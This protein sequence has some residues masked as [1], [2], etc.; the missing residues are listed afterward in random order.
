MRRGT[1]LR[2][3][4]AAA[5]MI[6][7]SVPP[8]SAAVE[9]ITVVIDDSLDPARVEVE[10]GTRV[11]WRN[12]DG[13]RHRIRSTS[14]PRE[15]DSGNIDSG[16]RFSFTFNVEGEYTYVDDRDR[17]NTAYHGTIVVTSDAAPPDPGEPP[18]PP[19][20]TGDV[21]IVD[22]RYQPA[23]IEVA[24]GA[25]ITWAN[26]DDRPHTVTANDRS[27]DSGVFDTG[28]SWAKTFTAAGSFAYFCTIHP[29]MVGTVI[30]TGTDGEPP[31][32]PP[33]TT[34]PPPAPPPPTPPPGATDVTIV[35]FN[36]A[37]GL[38]EV[39]VGTTVSWDNAG[40][41]PHTVTADNGSFDSGIMST[42]D[43]YNRTFN[44]AGTFAYLC[45][46][47]PEMV[48]TI[49]V[50]GGGGGGGEP[51][52][53]EPPPPDGDPPPPPPPPGASGV[54]IVDND[55]SPGTLRIA[56][57]TTVTWRNAG[58]LPHT[59]TANSGAFDSGFLSA[60]DSYRRTFHQPGTF[61]YLC[62][63]HPEMVG[64]VEV[65]GSPTGPDEPPPTVPPDVATP[66][67]APPSE[68]GPDSL[69]PLDPAQPSG[70]AIIDNAYDP[71]TLTVEA[72]TTVTW[73][74]VGVLPHTVTADDGA[75]DSGFLMTGDDYTLTLDTPGTFAYICTIHP[76]M[77][78]T[79]NV[80]AAAAT[81]GAAPANPA[82]SA[83]VASGEHAVAAAS[84]GP[85]GEAE[86]PPGALI[87][88]VLAGS[89]LATMVVFAI[90][91]ARFGK[92]AAEAR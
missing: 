61:A 27:W 34:T 19:P 87:A 60:G 36:F 58:A 12:D 66:D 51:P 38:L 68:A 33:P 46:L 54:N 56:T 77:V 15:F 9:T 49:V 24:V 88:Y 48:G 10:R 85:T 47:H 78:G 41:A 67:G 70:V 11:T 65:S 18:P 50:G 75:F 76:E 7:V 81:N 90:G 21:D 43:T 30:V 83:V 39:P 14:G 25:T 92:A 2:L 59:V 29:D 73:T 5:V 72:G 32:P 55:F 86:S 31:P 35:D 23:T 4:L 57:G 84:T 26:N 40:V 53:P 6:S 62:T 16:E 3:W 71:E 37:P 89:I 44:Q 63:I 69:S 13:D 64:T 42:G 1:W 8:A 20:A 74:N 28:R 80:V 82:E 22:R 17:D 79:I 52:A 45:T 91:M